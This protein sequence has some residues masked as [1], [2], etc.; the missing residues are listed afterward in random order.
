[1]HKRLAAAEAVAVADGAADDAAQYI[2]APLVGRR[3]PVHQQERGRAD[4]VGD[5]A[6]R[7]IVVVVHRQRV[8][9]GANQVAEQV[10]VVVAVHPLQHRG[11][12][13]QPHAGVDRRARQW[14]ERAIGVAVELH[15][16]QIPDFDVAVAVFFAIGG[17]PG[18]FTRDLRSVVVENLRARTARTGVAHR[19][20]IVARADAAEAACVHADVAQPDALGF[21]VFFIHRDPQALRRQREFAGQQLPR[22][23]DGFGFEVVAE[24]EVA[25]HLEEGVMA[26]GVA[27]IF[28]VVVLAAGAHTAL[29]GHRARRGAGLIAEEHILELHHPR[30]GEQQGRVIPRHQRTAGDVLMLARGE[31]VEE[32][33]ADV[34]GFHR[35]SLGKRGK[36]LDVL[37]GK[38]ALL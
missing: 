27:D 16:H 19:P 34:G 31:V 13:L 35:A 10:D 7:L 22:K 30:I 17:L 4:V 18:R 6:E 2:A 11:D 20:E 37:G 25:E 38:T 8:R 12:A 28:E 26:R 15:E 21:V 3:D 14:L 33:P 24:T 29:R 23:R 32:T 36:R 5:D 9:G 1:M